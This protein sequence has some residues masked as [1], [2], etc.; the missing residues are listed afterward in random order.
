MGLSAP[1]VGKAAGASLLGA[2]HSLALENPYI[3]E[4]CQLL[5]VLLP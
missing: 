4:L 3:S 1:S 2:A 5:Y